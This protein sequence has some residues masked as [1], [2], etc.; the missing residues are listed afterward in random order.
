MSIGALFLVVENPVWIDLGV[1]GI[2]FVG[3]VPGLGPR[4]DEYDIFAVEQSS[5]VLRGG[6]GIKYR[7][8]LPRERQVVMRVGGNQINTQATRRF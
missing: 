7:L 4:L 1:E 2:E 5:S 6:K 8:W 3:E